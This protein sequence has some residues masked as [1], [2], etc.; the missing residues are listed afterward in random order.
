MVEERLW[1]R[2]RCLQGL[3]ANH[4]TTSC[5]FVGDVRSFVLFM[6]V[7]G[8]YFKSHLYSILENYFKGGYSVQRT[9]RTHEIQGM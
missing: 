9:V 7:I 6:H 1:V 4:T 2:N 8:D 3:Q 5:H